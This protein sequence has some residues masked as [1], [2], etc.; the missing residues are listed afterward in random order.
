MQFEINRF[1]AQRFAEARTCASCVCDAP[2]G[3][4]TR[5]ATLIWTNQQQNLDIHTFH[6]FINPN[7]QNNTRNAT[8]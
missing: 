5:L 6:S 1:I 3:A 8:V 7:K 2:R 4:G